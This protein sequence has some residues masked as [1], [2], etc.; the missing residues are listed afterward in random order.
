MD[1]NKGGRKRE[2]GREGDTHQ[3]E[4]N[5]HPL[6]GVSA[7]VNY[8]QMFFAAKKSFAQRRRNEHNTKLETKKITKTQ[9]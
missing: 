7:L 2:G 5:W 3:L 6:F 4:N 8:F 9:T 1:G